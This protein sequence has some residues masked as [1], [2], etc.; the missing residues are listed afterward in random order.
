MSFSQLCSSLEITSESQKTQLL[1]FVQDVA[2]LVQGN[3]VIKSE[4]LYPAPVKNEPVK[5]T[6]VSG[7]HPV[8]LTKA[9][10]YV[11]RVKLF[12]HDK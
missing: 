10:N 7:I 2:E 11:V 6:G 9:R 5:L 3:W 8:I 12:T 1:N 4:I